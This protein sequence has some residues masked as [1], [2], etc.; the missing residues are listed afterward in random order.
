MISYNP[1]GRPR[2]AYVMNGS[3]RKSGGA[4][5]SHSETMMTSFVRQ[6][7]YASMQKRFL[8]EAL[9]E[10]KA[11]ENKVDSE[12]SVPAQEIVWSNQELGT[13]NAGHSGVRMATCWGS[14]AGTKPA[15]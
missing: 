15:G 5:R 4:M 6:R 11:E 3:T 9:Q 13:A 12:G 8:E 14:Y 1:R 7:T 2:I 10:A